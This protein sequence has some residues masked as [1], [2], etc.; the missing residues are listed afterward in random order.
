M[1]GSRKNFI[2]QDDTGQIYAINLDESNTEAVNGGTNDIPDTTTA[3]VGVPRNIRP[4]EIFFKSV[5]GRRTIRTVALTTQIYQS[6][7]NG[8]LTEIPDPLNPL[9]Q[10]LQLARLNG[11]RR[12]VYPGI[13]TGLDDGDPT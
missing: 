6:I 5:D 10:G 7:V 1:A 11:E 4:R 3:T 2:Y 9:G 8:A 12:R 13:D